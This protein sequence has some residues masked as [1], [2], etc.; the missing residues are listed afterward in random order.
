MTNLNTA[1]SNAVNTLNILADKSNPSAIKALDPFDIVCAIAYVARDTSLFHELVGADTHPKMQ[2]IIGRTML[3]NAHIN[4]ALAAQAITDAFE[5]LDAA[6]LQ[7]T[8]QSIRGM[9]LNL[10]HVDD[11]GICCNDS[12]A[13][14]EDNTFHL[15]DSSSVL[16]QWGA[17]QYYDAA[18]NKIDTATYSSYTDQQKAQCKQVRFMFIAGYNGMQHHVDQYKTDWLREGIMRDIVEHFGVAMR[19]ACEL[20]NV[21]SNNRGRAYEHRDI[22]LDALGKLPSPEFSNN[23]FMKQLSDGRI[24]SYGEFM[25]ASM[26][27]LLDIQSNNIMKAPDTDILRYV[28]WAQIFSTLTAEGERLKYVSVE[29]MDNYHDKNGNPLKGVDDHGNIMTSGTT[30]GGRKSYINHLGLAVSEKLFK[31]VVAGSII[32]PRS[33]NVVTAVNALYASLHQV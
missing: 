17:Q 9:V 25:I 21:D 14:L 30:M 18:G 23:G 3:V 20:Y 19:Y 33:K 31:D 10:A 2:D 8:L 16:P 6:S 24:K 5:H 7:K 26:E 28:S 11:N 12:G 32:N 29:D 22:I 1:I 13:P 4:T 15:L 27:A